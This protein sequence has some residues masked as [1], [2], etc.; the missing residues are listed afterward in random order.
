MSLSI[1]QAGLIPDADIERAKED[2]KEAA[3]KTEDALKNA[4][5]ATKTAGANAMVRDAI[6][7]GLRGRELETVA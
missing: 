6:L 7:S 4:A 3:N 1:M 2:I 5:D